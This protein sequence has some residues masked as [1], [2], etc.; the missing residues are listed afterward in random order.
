MRAQ[1]VATTLIAAGLS[2]TCLA[3][4]AARM[5]PRPADQQVSICHKG[6]TISV[7]RSALD[8]HLGHGD[9]VGACRQGASE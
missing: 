5:V 4:C 1:F 3:G 9:S 7:G 6:K 8:V 2:L